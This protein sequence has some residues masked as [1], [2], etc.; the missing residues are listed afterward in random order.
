MLETVPILI[1]YTVKCDKL[2]KT[3]LADVRQESAA[4]T[5]WLT[6]TVDKNQKWLANQSEL[7]FAAGLLDV[8]FAFSPA[9]NTLHIQRLNL[10]V[11]ETKAV[12]AVWVLSEQLKL[13]KIGQTYSRI[14]EW[15]YDYVHPASNF[16]AF[17]EVDELGLIVQ[18]GDLWRRLQ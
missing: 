3:Q 11:G 12:E 13:E 17:L 14:D 10:K 16:R 4:R 18:Y 15:H 1:E 8:D 9:T 6:L 5:N 7:L 2:W